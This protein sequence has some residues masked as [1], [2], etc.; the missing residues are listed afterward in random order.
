MNWIY[1]RIPEFIIVKLPYCYWIMQQH[2]KG[3]YHYGGKTGKKVHII[4]LKVDSD[5]GQLGCTVQRH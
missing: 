3:K 4:W 5:T 1:S 2:N